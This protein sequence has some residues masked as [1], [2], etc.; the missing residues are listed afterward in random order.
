MSVDTARN[1]MRAA[2][3]YGKKGTFLLLPAAA[4]YE[5]AVP[6]TPERVRQEV[7]AHAT[8]SETVTAAEIKRLKAEPPADAQKGRAGG[9]RAA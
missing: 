7:E 3:V 1:F 4:L 2:D 5:L 8:K 6:S 9:Y